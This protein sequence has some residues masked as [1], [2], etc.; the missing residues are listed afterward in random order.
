M[1]IWKLGHLNVEREIIDKKRS[2]EVDRLLYAVSTFIGLS[3]SI[4]LLYM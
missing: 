2:K 1:G 4:T 3:N